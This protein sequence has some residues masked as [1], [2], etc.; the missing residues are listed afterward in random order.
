MSKRVIVTGAAG[1]IG[2]ALV[3]DLL[4]FT[5]WQVTGLDA[6]TYAGNLVNLTECTAN[7]RFD[8]VQADI[9]NRAHISEIFEQR[10]PQVVFHLAAESHVDRSIDKADDFITTNVGGTQILLDCARDI[11]HKSR[12]LRF[13]HISTD[14]VF[15]DLTPSQPAFT[16]LSPYQPSSPYAAS[17]AASDH[18]VR[19]AFRTHGLPILISNCS[20]NYGPRQFPE[21]LIP[22]MIANALN[23]L[24]FPIYGDGSNVRDWLFVDDHATALRIMAQRGAL[25]ETYCIGG[26]AEMSNLDVVKAVHE[27]V[28][29]RFPDLATA[30]ETRLTFVTDRPGHDR[31]YAI[32][33]SKAQRDLGWAPKVSFQQGLE[34]T[35]AWYV[36]NTEWLEAIK[37]G[38]YRGERLGLATAGNA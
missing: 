8:F 34:Q 20:N 38:T 26:G 36:E 12:D 13:V 33:S 29:A 2:S 28:C 14:E 18:L 24:T 17:K 22:L 30:F 10:S 27:I 21:K 16:E 19:A 11:F 4:A 35:V 7:D 31:R 23:G 37:M 25:G 32:N 5:D 3:R 9:R 15:G 6:L 1:F